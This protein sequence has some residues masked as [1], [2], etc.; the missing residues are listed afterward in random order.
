MLSLKEFGITESSS[1]FC[2]CEVS[3][4]NEGFV[5]TKR[6]PDQMACLPDRMTLNSRYVY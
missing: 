5:K 6:L 4:E 1:N 3:V 2:L